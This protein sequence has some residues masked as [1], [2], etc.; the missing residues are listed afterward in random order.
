VAP[1]LYS[2]SA[3][4]ALRLY[5]CPSI[6]PGIPAKQLASLAGRESQQQASHVFVRR[7]LEQN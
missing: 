4:F 5:F 3:N 6:S 1:I 2:G 7:P